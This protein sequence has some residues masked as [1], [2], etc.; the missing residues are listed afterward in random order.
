[1]SCFIPTSVQERTIRKEKFFQFLG[2]EIK[3]LLLEV[4]AGKKD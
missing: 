1:M 4:K 2:D 3:A